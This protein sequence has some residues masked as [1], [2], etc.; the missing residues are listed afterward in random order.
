M[1]LG[2]WGTI[3]DWV[4]IVRVEVRVCSLQLQSP[5]AESEPMR[6]LK[7]MAYS[8]SVGIQCSWTLRCILYVQYCTALCVC[9]C[10]C[11]Y[12]C[13]VYRRGT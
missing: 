10:V 1:L 13:Q 2:Y 12:T 4:S 8:N 6:H 9:V 11:M 7:V 5:K 3:L